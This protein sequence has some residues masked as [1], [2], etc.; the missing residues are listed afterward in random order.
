MPRLSN[1]T[2]GLIVLAA[3]WLFV[4]ISASM[5]AKD[6]PV[7]DQALID[8]A[9]DVLGSLQSQSF[10]ENREYCGVI[11]RD[12]SRELKHTEIFEGDRDGCSFDYP[13]NWAHVPRASFHTHGKFDP[14]TDSE[15][16]SLLDMDGDIND[17][18]LGFIST[19]GGR[20]WMVDW[21]TETATQVCG[22]GCLP[23]DPKFLACP[24]FAPKERYTL[25]ELETRFDTDTF[26]C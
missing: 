25:S 13:E 15:V 20:L 18:V 6:G 21:D 11:Y 8:F 4:V 22:I 9:K 16:P 14:A 19:P 2:I 10:Q 3:L 26:N 1:T 12:D 17:R 23:K 5:R 24:G 7:A